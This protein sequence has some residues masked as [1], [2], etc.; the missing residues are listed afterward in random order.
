[1]DQQLITIP[2][3]YS[4]SN[5]PEPL[6]L[7]G[8]V[9]SIQFSSDGDPLWVVSGRWRME[10]DIDNTGNVPTEIKN[11]TTDL[12]VVPADGSVTERY[13]LLDFKQD[14]ISYD[15]NTKTS[16]TKGK[17]TMTVKDQRVENIETELKLINKNI[18]TITLD[19]TK[20]RDQLGETPIYGIE[21]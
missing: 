19:P 20:T 15:N 6:K 8:P 5:P 12:V 10:L 1:M 7:D 18:L 14:G 16:S 21:R 11:F 4:S 3:A 2:F 13:E 9:S 17:L